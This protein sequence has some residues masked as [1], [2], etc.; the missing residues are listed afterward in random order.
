MATSS[1]GDKDM[2]DTS[3]FD[4]VRLLAAQP[5][6]AGIG[7]DQLLDLS[8]G[9]TLRRVCRGELVSRQGDPCDALYIVLT[10]QIKLFVVSR[11]GQEKVA[12][13]AGPGCSFNESTL[14]EG[15]ACLLSSQ[16]MSDVLLLSVRRQAVLDEVQRD[17]SFAMRML[18]NLSRRLQCAMRDLQSQTLETGMQRVV[19]YLMRQ[20]GETGPAA[21]GLRLSLPVNKAT[22]ASLLSITPEYFSRVLSELEQAG[23]IKVDRRD[24][25]IVDAKRLAVCQA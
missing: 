19:G 7:N 9:S 18:S 16:A 4:L 20:A 25:T 11:S 14:F 5:I 12:E 17:G 1:K 24:I 6:F 10:G 8:R 21:S 15:Q 2:L 23:L 3:R 13:V 22:I